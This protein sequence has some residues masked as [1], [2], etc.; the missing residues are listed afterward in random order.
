MK[1]I[2][3]KEAFIYCTQCHLDMLKAYDGY[4]DNASLIEALVKLEAVERDRVSLCDVKGYRNPY[5]DM[6]AEELEIEIE[7]GRES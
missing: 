7:N 3:R 6:L 1:N 2:S 4:E 5:L